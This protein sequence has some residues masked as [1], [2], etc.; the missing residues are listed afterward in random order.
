MDR[1]AMAASRDIA[2]Q[3]NPAPLLPV[4]DV[5]PEEMERD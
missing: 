4:A 3:P 1:S 2:N 5:G